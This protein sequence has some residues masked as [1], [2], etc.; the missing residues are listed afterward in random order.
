MDLQTLSPVWE[1][2]LDLIYPAR[3]CVCDRI[4]DGYFCGIC[5]AEI[6]PP[7]APHCE[8][9]QDPSG[10]DLCARCR[11][12]P[13][14]FALARSAGSFD[15]RL[16][17]AILALKYGRRAHVAPALAEVL[18][19]A[20]RREPRLRDADALIPLPIHP[21][22]ERER[23]FNQSSLLA[24]NLGRRLAIPVLSDSLVRP[25]YRRAQV[26]LGSRERWANVSGVFH[27]ATPDQVAGR[28][29]LL[30]DDVL[31]TG[32]TCSEA[33]KSLRAAGAREVLVLTVAR[34][35]RRPASDSTR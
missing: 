21:K 2:L 26:G 15:G 29:L 16:R 19:D 33:A 20:W 23:G 18:E 35:S 9:C 11:R 30:I 8:R 24:E 28:T 14:R 12:D 32:A 6:A 31:T 27:V 17:L 1:A 22:R 34:E 7:T 13:P 3:C 5:R 25:I 4:G 10:P